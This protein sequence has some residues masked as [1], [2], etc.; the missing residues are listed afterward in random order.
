MWIQTPGAVND[1]LM[2]FGTRRNTLYLVKGDRHMLIGGGGQWIVAELERQFREYRIDMDRIQYL[3][4]GHTHYDHCGA[5]PYLRRRYPHL[6]VLASRE[7]EK[8]YGME[9]AQRNM[10]TFSHQVMREMGLPLE[11]EGVSLEFDKIHVDR[12]LEDGDRVDLG[13]GL[14]FGVIETP[15][16]SRCSITLCE[17]QEKW[18]F[19]SDSMAVPVGKDDRFMSTAS[20]S[21][22][23][24]LDSL[25]KLAALDTR[26]C[27]WEHFGVMTDEDARDIVRRVIRYTMEYKHSLV[28]HVGQTGD[29]EKT[30]RWAARDWLATTGFEFLTFD[31]MLHIARVMVKNA[32]EEQVNQS[33]Y[34]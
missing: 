33:C 19:P 14:S 4:I 2:L 31:V 22:I 7:A 13:S 3:L 27:A 25:K 23:V 15:G 32:L 24:Y 34:L 30:A 9:K 6:Q 1:R 28:E 21:F 12:V 5:I 29:V 11:F 10:R 17:P 8:L 26:L 18:L 16:H 20:E